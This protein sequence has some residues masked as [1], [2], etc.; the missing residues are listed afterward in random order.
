MI[1]GLLAI[2]REGPLELRLTPAQSRNLR[3]LE[4]RIQTVLRENRRRPDPIDE[5]VRR[6]L[7]LAQKDKIRE[8]RLSELPADMTE[9]L[10]PFHDLLEQLARK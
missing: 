5:E 6:C 9:Y 8:R 2:H 3:K 1:L 7:T 4:T 10:Q